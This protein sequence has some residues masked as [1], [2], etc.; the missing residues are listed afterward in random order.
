MS[1]ANKG[2]D[3][4]KGGKGGKGD[5]KEIKICSNCGKRNHSHDTCRWKG[6]GDEQH[7]TK[8]GNYGHKTE[9]HEDFISNQQRRGGPKKSRNDKASMASEEQKATDG[10]LSWIG[11]VTD[12]EPTVQAFQASDKP[13]AI[14]DSGATQHL[15]CTRVSWIRAALSNVQRFLYPRNITI[16][17]DSDFDIHEHATIA[18]GVKEDT[19]KETTQETVADTIKTVMF[20]PATPDSR[21]K[22]I[23]QNQDN[24]L[25]K[26]MNCPQVRFIERAGTTI[27]EDL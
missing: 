20:V 23:L 17:D 8:C 10:S 24:I 7:C 25:C 9:N 12:S 16:A 6:G 2:G 21:L 15:A 27:V 5:K 14:M 3:K 11:M 26:S 1:S 22:T 18:V 13:T 19:G 4:G